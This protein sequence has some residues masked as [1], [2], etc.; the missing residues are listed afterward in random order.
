MFALAFFEA[1]VRTKHQI[2]AH[3]WSACLL[4]INVFKD[5]EVAKNKETAAAA[6]ERLNV[7]RRSSRWDVCWTIIINLKKIIKELTPE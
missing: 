6:L 7:S 2:C 4:L 5:R 3:G 1:N